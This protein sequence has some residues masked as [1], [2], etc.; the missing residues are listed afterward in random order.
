LLDTLPL[1]RVD[2]MI[3]D[4]SQDMKSGEVRLRHTSTHMSVSSSTSSS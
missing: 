3:A 4:S 2:S 1:D